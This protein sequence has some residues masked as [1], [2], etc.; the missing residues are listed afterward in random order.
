MKRK[1]IL[2][3]IS[4]LAL[5][6]LL[7]A[8]GGNE[9]QSKTE[10]S[11]ATSLN[12]SNGKDGKDGRSIVSIAK[13]DSKGD[14]DTYTVSYSDGTTSTFTITNG[15][16]G[17]KGD[18]GDTP[19]VTIGMNGN[20]YIN[21]VDSGISA[22]GKQ[23]EAGEKGE[24][25]RSVKS[26]AKTG[27][28]GNVD[29]YTI[30][31]SNGDTSTFTITNGTNGEKGS[32]GSSV[33]TGPGAPSNDLGSNG[34]SYIDL[35]TYDYYVKE[36]DEWK[37]KGNIKG[38]DGAYVTGT[39]I[40]DN[41]DLIVTL[42]DGNTYNAGHVK[43]IAKSHKVNFIVD[44]TIKKTI[45]VPDGSKIARPS[46]DDFPGYTIASWNVK[47][48]GG[49]RWLYSVYTVTSDIDLYAVYATNSYMVTI[50]EEKFSLGNKVYT[51][52]YGEAY[53]FS[54]AYFKEGYSFSLVDEE[55]IIYPLRGNWEY[56]KDTTL[57][58]KWQG[59]SHSLT[60]ATNDAAMGN[61]IV[62]SGETRY[63]EEIT[64][65]A[66]PTSGNAF[67]GWYKDDEL[68]SYNT[69]YVFNM[70][71]EDLTLTAKFVTQEDYDKIA[72]LAMRPTF[73]ENKEFITYG[74]YPQSHVKDTKIKN[75]LDNASQM[76]WLV[77]YNGDYY[78]R[79]TAAP[80]ND[81]TTY[82]YSDGSSISKG[83][84]GWFKLEPIKW[85][86]KQ[87][88]SSG[89][90]V[91]YSDVILGWSQYAT[92]SA[93]DY[94]GS[95]LRSWLTGDFANVAFA[96]NKE[97]LLDYEVNVTP[98]N[99]NS[100]PKSS[101]DHKAC[102]DKVFALTQ[103]EYRFS[104]EYA[105]Y[106]SSVTSD[107]ARALGAYTASSTGY[108]SYW[109]ATPVRDTGDKAFYITEDGDRTATT[110]TEYKGVRPSISLKMPE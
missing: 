31:Y 45:N 29:T 20:W 96:F 38:K 91:L 58:V 106:S 77:E 15:A 32:D 33:L 68:L 89:A 23:G 11:G 105:I 10:N 67:Y 83:K 36:K 27:S 34:D 86:I 108:G 28:Q 22:L 64:I 21:G 107:Y 80:Y 50:K 39:K 49:Y 6:S 18:A 5:I 110:I 43:D 8:C 109:A 84:T 30:I 48:D 35:S 24:E 72:K 9:S 99:A 52:S 95:A 88:L 2:Y 60:L 73:D 69:T 4:S 17:D 93:N 61:G 57:Y 51:L 104:G 46:D 70:P 75:E 71:N 94:Y 90:Y 82:A 97:Y 41:G 62:K 79:A 85:R 100:E 87:Q 26:I 37:P 1:P 40:D 56:A 19:V 13:T 55:G 92:G 81:E 101:S 74:L 7:A 103:Y 102:T 44:G 78:A 65:E 3:V 76:M 12:G 25:G 63:N 42:S 16:K 54:G 66:V 98:T 59:L 14:V 47:E 53:D